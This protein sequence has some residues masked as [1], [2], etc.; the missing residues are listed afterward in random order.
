MPFEE[1]CNKEK[2]VSTTSYFQGI[3]NL[4]NAILSIY[5][6]LRLI[7]GGFFFMCVCAHRPVAMAQMAFPATSAALVF[8][9]L[10]PQI[11]FQL[12]KLYLPSFASLF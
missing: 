7:G 11:R 8:F 5:K 10:I 6:G 1:N 2:G 4:I 9:F 3:R 12:L